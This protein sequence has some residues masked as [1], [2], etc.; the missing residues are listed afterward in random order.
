MADTSKQWKVREKKK[1]KS[2]VADVQVCLPLGLTVDS[3]LPLFEGKSLCFVT[4]NRKHGCTFRPWLFVEGGT[5]E[6]AKHILS[7]PY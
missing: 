5:L 1:E 3:G 6:L 7:L 4:Q 2:G